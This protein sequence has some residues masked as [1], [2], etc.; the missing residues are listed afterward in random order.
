[1]RAAHGQRRFKWRWHALTRSYLECLC[2]GFP[3]PGS[4]FLRERYL[5][6]PPRGD[7]EDVAVGNRG[8]IWPSLFQTQSLRTQL[9]T[10]IEPVSLPSV[11]IFYRDELPISLFNY[12][13]EAGEAQRLATQIQARRLYLSAR[14]CVLTGLVR[15]LVNQ[16]SLKDKFV[17]EHISLH[18]LVIKP[19]WAVHQR[20]QGRNGNGI[21]QRA[22]V[23][24]KPPLVGDGHT[25][26]WWREQSRHRKDQSGRKSVV[27][28]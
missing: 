15:S 26:P 28:C 23:H 12:V 3:G 1:M 19:A 11:L 8:F 25:R 9:N 5:H 18:K 24:R 7:I 20:I 10:V 14:R 21:G 22:I 4:Q 13:R 16:R 2:N 17:D 27:C 6:A